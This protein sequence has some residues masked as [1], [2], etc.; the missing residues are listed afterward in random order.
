MKDKYK[1]VAFAILLL[2]NFHICYAEQGNALSKITIPIYEKAYSITDTTSKTAGGTSVFYKV[3]LPFP[4]VEVISFYN[5]VFQEQ[6]YLP[7]SEDEYG[8]RRWENLNP[9]TGNWEKT[10]HVPAR[11]IATWVD[12]NRT[13]RIVLFIRYKYDYN[14]KAWEKTLLVNCSKEKYFTMN[15][16]K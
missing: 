9:S 13:T 8:N 2:V 1:F 5:K 4:G 15:E 12:R 7:F 11:Y 6:G 16:N 3:G 10:D 14:D